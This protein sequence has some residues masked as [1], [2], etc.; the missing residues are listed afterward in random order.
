MTCI[1]LDGFKGVTNLFQHI[2]LFVFLSELDWLNNKSFL[3]GDALSLHSRFTENSEKP[4]Q[5]EPR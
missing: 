1:I 2:L 5:R 3:T 4:N